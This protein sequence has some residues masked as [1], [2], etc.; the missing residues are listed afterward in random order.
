MPPS[1]R[2]PSARPSPASPDAATA[3]K[4]RAVLRKK[5][6]DPAAIA[7]V[8]RKLVDGLNAEQKAAATAADGAVL[9]V[10]G[11]GSGKTRVLVTRIAHLLARGVDPGSIAALTF[12]NRAAKEMRARLH[13]FTGKASSGVSVGT[14]HS[15]GYRLVREFAGPLGLA[16]EPGILDMHSRLSLLMTQAARPGPRTRNST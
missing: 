13:A 14:F 6:T 12:S 10:A 11:A 5:G 8:V 15:L 4:A 9:V 3:A 16:P 1:P 7:G 2:K